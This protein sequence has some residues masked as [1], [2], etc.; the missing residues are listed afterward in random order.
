M[1]GVIDQE[2]FFTQVAKTKNNK[3]GDYSCSTI[4]KWTHPSQRAH[5]QC[6]QAH[7]ITCSHVYT[8][9]HIHHTHTHTHMEFIVC[10]GLFTGRGGHRKPDT[11]YMVDVSDE[12]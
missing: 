11:M 6:T 1:D 4:L 7:T 5:T 8:N 9:V 12:V 3:Y 10:P 2:H